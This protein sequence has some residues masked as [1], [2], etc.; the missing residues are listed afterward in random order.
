MCNTSIIP[1]KHHSKVNCQCCH[2]Q[3]LEKAMGYFPDNM[4]ERPVLEYELTPCSKCILLKQCTVG[5]L[6]VGKQ[7]KATPILVI[8]WICFICAAL[9]G[10]EMLVQA[11]YSQACTSQKPSFHPLSLLQT[12]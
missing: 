11:Q 7:S 10:R 12:K 3:F 4:S 2:H 6:C 8:G 1:F 9:R 5:G